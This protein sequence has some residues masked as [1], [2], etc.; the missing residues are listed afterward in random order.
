MTQRDS[1]IFPERFPKNSF[2]SEIISER[3][4]EFPNAH[5]SVRNRIIS[6]YF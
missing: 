4:K 6:G 1:C 3:R 2:I 5:I